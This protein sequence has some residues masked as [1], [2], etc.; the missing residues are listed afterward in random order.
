MSFLKGIQIFKVGEKTEK[1]KGW[2]LSRY[3]RGTLTLFP[4]TTGRD[5]KG[6]R[7]VVRALCHSL[8]K[9]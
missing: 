1:K 2:L 9:Y 3:L 6:L 4:G 5:L 8:Q 7:K